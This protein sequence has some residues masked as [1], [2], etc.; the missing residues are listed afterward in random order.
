[1]SLVEPLYLAFLAAVVTL[2]YALPAGRA[3]IALLALAGYAFYCLLSPRF[4]FVLVVVVLLAYLGGRL[5]GAWRD[6]RRGSVILAAS[7]V[8][9]LL[10]LVYYKYAAFVLGEFDA[11]LALDPPWPA[12]WSAGDVLLAIGISFYVFQAIAYVAD[13]YLGV[14]EAERDF[15]RFALFLA[16]FPILSAGPIERYARL[17]PQFDRDVALRAEP[18]V[19]GF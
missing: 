17:M 10:P 8:L 6:H 19:A 15:V 16:F 13:V 18:L 1:M 4:W 12:E 11:V 2:Y 7:V 14:A 9:L 5:V 3:R